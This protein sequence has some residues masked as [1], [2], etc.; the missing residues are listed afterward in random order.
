M[1]LNI[2]CIIFLTM[3]DWCA[4]SFDEPVPDLN[5]EIENKIGEPIIVTSETVYKNY[6][7]FQPNDYV[8]LPTIMDTIYAYETRTLI[9]GYEE[10]ISRHRNIQ[11]LLWEQSTLDRFSEEEIIAK[12]IYDKRYKFSLSDFKNGNN[13]IVYNGK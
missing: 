4:E 12:N 9:V 13:R 5:V 3:L 10:H 2:L 11:I 1:R 6:E 8:Q 7:I